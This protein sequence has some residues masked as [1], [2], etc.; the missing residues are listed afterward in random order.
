MMKIIIPSPSEAEVEYTYSDSKLESYLQRIPRIESNNSGHLGGRENG[1]EEKRRSRSSTSCMK[2]NL[3]GGEPPP[4]QSDPLP[5]N[6][7][8]QEE[9]Q[10]QPKTGARELK[11]NQLGGESPS[12]QSDPMPD[13]CKEQEGQHYKPKTRARVLVAKSSTDIPPKMNARLCFQSPI[14]SDAPRTPRTF[15]APLTLSC[16]SLF[17]KNPLDEK[18]PLAINLAPAAMTHAPEE[19]EE[20]PM[21]PVA[22]V[23]QLG[24][25]FFSSWK[26][27]MQ[28]PKQDNSA[29]AKLISQELCSPSMGPSQD[30]LLLRKALKQQRQQAKMATTIPPLVPPPTTSLNCPSPKAPPPPFQSPNSKKAQQISQALCKTQS[31][32]D[33]AGLFF[34]ID[35]PPTKAVQTIAIEPHHS[36]YWEEGEVTD[37]WDSFHENQEMLIKNAVIQ[38]TAVALMP[39]PPS[40][41]DSPEIPIDDDNGEEKKEDKAESSLYILL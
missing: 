37:P 2:E 31:N 19:K 18:L 10:Q 4:S 24:S 11:E 36:P 3:L 13:I 33:C 34:T 38:K 29:K 39:E 17:P 12:S 25:D 30:V 40:L 26:Q 22:K 35:S 8:A 23:R 1:E 5:E 9:R 7:K 27:S 41:D 32:M 28:S 15:K 6:C 16:K 21:T 14:I 20:T